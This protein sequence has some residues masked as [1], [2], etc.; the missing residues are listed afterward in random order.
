MNANHKRRTFTKIPVVNNT[1]MSEKK[2]ILILINK[3]G[4]QNIKH[5]RV[6]LTLTRNVDKLLELN[7]DENARKTG[8]LE[9]I[10]RNEIQIKDGM[11]FQDI[12]NM[13]FKEEDRLKRVSKSI[14]GLPFN[15]PGIEHQTERKQLVVTFSANQKEN[16]NINLI[17]PKILD[18]SIYQEDKSSSP[19]VI[20]KNSWTQIDKNEFTSESSSQTNPMSL[21]AISPLDTTLTRPKSNDGELADKGKNSNTNNQQKMAKLMRKR[22]R[23]SS[24]ESSLPSK[25]MKNKQTNIKKYFDKPLSNVIFES[26]TSAHETN[27]QITKTS[28]ASGNDDSEEDAESLATI[29]EGVPLSS[30]HSNAIASNI[31]NLP[32]STD[33]RIS[34]EFKPFARLRSVL[35]VRDLF[36]KLQKEE[37]PPQMTDEDIE[38]L[39]SEFEQTRSETTTFVGI[40]NLVQ[41]IA[42]D[43]WVK[44]GN[45]LETHL[46]DVT[47]VS[48]LWPIFRLGKAKSELTIIYQLFSIY[49]SKFFEKMKKFSTYYSPNDVD[50]LNEMSDSMKL[51]YVLTQMEGWKEFCLWEEHIRVYINELCHSGTINSVSSLGPSY[52]PRYL[53]RGHNFK[54]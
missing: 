18:L 9:G 35:K 50:R 16:P 21:S 28:Q 10:L 54:K 45:F 5:V 25:I 37:A 6:P 47:E 3:D 31:S 48:E 33:K 13:Y 17:K 44:V 15:I 26:T 46:K 43:K 11:S 19:D 51:L 32:L 30:Q 49:E 1:P 39:K 41:A 22:L 40:N 38:E 36:N 8:S 2:G 23:Q 53:N 7:G 52:V 4:S 14:T 42:S 20:T 12:A 29:I 24:S 34:N 27:G